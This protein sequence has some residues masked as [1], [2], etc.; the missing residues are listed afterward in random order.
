MIRRPPRSTRT[1]TLFPDT[2]LFRSAVRAG[3]RGLR[4]AAGG[5]FG[6]EV[7][8]LRLQT[9]GIDEIGGQDL[10]D[11]LR[12][13]LATHLHGHDAVGADRDALRA[14][15]DLD[16][17]LQRITA[18]RDDL[19]LAVRLESTVARVRERAVRHLHLEEA[20]TVDRD[21]ERS[22]VRRVGKECVSKF[23]SRWSP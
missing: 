2:T 17:R 20:A 12:L 21:I 14:G 9:R 3:R 10:A 16:T 1:D 4:R 5:G 11:L 23:R 22:E 7:F 13:R 18:G 19:A 6:I 8:A 15:R